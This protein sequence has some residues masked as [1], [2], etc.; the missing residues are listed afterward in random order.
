[1]W[2]WKPWVLLPTDASP[3]SRSTTVEPNPGRR[4]LPDFF[5]IFLDIGLKVGIHAADKQTEEE[6]PPKLWDWLRA[7]GNPASAGA[8]L[9]LSVPRLTGL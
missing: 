7:R 1:M 8:T 9:R 2:A 4:V 3:Y 5:Y 6:G